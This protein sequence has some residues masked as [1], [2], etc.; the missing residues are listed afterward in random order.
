MD[1]YDVCVVGS[2]IAGTFAALKIAKDHK[3]TK[4]LLI[5]AGPRPAKRR[6]QCQGFLGLAPNSDGKMFIND[7]SII[8]QIAGT[9]KTNAAYKWFSNYAK[10]IMSLQTT[11]D[12]SPI[13]S[14]EKKIKK[15]GFDILLNNFIQ[16]YPKDIH[17]LSKH[18]AEILYSS[19]NISTS[20]DNEVFDIK[21]QKRSF[22]ITAQEGQV[23][24]KRVIIAMGRSGWRQVTQLYEEFAIIENNDTAKFGIRIEA[25]SAV[26][27]DFNKS[28]C[29]LIKDGLRLGPL[30]NNGSVVPEDHV[31]FACA[32]FRSNEGRWNSDKVSFELMADRIFPGKGVEET[33][34]LA[35]LMFVLCNDRIVKE[36]LSSIIS[37]KSTIS[38]LKEFDF[39]IPELK[40][41]NEWFPDLIS[42]GYFNI[43][44][45]YPM[46]PN[47]NVGSN[48]STKANGVYCAGESG[49]VHGILA[50][51]V[52]GLIVGDSV[53][54]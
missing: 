27:R 20:F 26:M 35:Q 46:I 28:N 16:I 31:D 49:G 34:R 12:R 17:T 54:K 47:I 42:K 2:G 15:A 8:S 19:K 40:G 6:P 14:M 33:D 44:C 9:K 24:A 7:L 50:A 52:S 4:T 41:I 11:K 51:I 38:V 45:V 1:K 21:K 30:S 3:N 22:I 25:T 5:D 29:T 13:T 39:I 43:P 53:C 10:P 37:K 23:E 18:I 48:F 32:S 36:K